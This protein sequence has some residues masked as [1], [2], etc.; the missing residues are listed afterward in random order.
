LIVHRADWV[1][2]IASPPIRDGWVAVDRGRIAA[3]GMADVSPAEPHPVPRPFS[4]H[5]CAILPA[6]VNAHT[7]I[8]LSYLGAHVPPSDRFDDWIRSL[9]ALRR[10]PPEAA[11][12]LDGAR[13]GIQQ[14]HGSGTGLVGD[15]SN[16]L[17]TV[18]LFQQAGVAAHVFHELIGFNSADSD[19]RVR[20]ARARL[21][22]I[23][24][25]DE[26]VRV[27]LA[28]HAPYS[29]S[30]GLFKAI[31]QDLDTHP[32]TVS[33]VHLG[34]SRDE[35][36]FLQHGG[37]AIRTALEAFGAW[38][39][40]WTAPAC[41]PVEYIARFGLLHRRMLIVH[42]VQLTDAELQRVRTA[43]ATIV[44]CPRSNGW[45]GA[46]TPP[47][48]RFYASGVRVAI[49]TDSLASV[50]DLNLFSELAAVRRLA[51]GVAASRILESATRAGAEALAFGDQWGT[52][53]PGKRS[54]LIAVR[55]PPD[56]VD[57]EEYLLTGI[58]PADIRW[59]EQ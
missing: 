47:V 5:P 50:D 43:D 16:T 35:I 59:L 20:S 8:E 7:H 18:P 10:Q 39:S 26:D 28:P 49:G 11:E 1:L 17:V 21:D 46:G 36:E 32:G 27:S 54:E 25:L 15:V 34:E 4:D 40:E 48:D 3:C 58:Q 29:V 55:I 9:V 51:P 24:D 13:A 22:A 37:G 42:A 19:A 56:V 41:G 30:P 2:P 38:T 33:S 44:M 53:E 12:V 52:I 23:R 6:L 14:V 31:R 57:V 45:T